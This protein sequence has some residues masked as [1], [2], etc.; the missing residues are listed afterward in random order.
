MKRSWSA[1][2]GL[3]LFSSVAANCLASEEQGR[4]AMWIDIY[5]G[6]PISYG[7]MIEDLAGAGIIYLG[8]HHT[9]VRHHEIQAGVLKDLAERGRLLVVGLEQMESIRQPALDR[10]NRGQIDFDQ[11]ASETDWGNRWRNYAQYRPLLETARRFNVPVIA[12]NA[13]AETI[14]QVFRSG[15]V[16]KL[17]PETRRELPEDLELKD[18]D[19]EALLK[20]QMM[21]H[22]SAQETMLRPMIEAQIARDE[23]MASVLANYLKSPAGNGRTAVVIC[24]AGHV[25]YGLGTAARVQRRLPEVRQRIVLL[26]E[27]GDVELSP[28]EK[29]MA[30]E[31]EITHEQLRRI[32]RPIGDYL[33]AKEPAD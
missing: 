23:A 19:Y 11:L 3:L 25:A 13:R 15:G 33:H 10:F 31:I 17:P 20:L 21:V 32:A 6:E 16:E 2:A 4:C 5:R 28:E 18:P 9:L 1:V 12:M 7:E 14:R 8:E 30:R 22:A 26:S 24:G 29:A 27:S